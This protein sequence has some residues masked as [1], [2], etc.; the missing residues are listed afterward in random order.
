MTKWK[1]SKHVGMKNDNS[2]W[3]ETKERLAVETLR[4]SRH[5]MAKV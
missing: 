3:K 5:E 2:R 1:K 4:P